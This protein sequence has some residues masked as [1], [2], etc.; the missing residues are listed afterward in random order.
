MYWWRCSSSCILL[1][2][3]LPFAVVSPSPDRCGTLENTKNP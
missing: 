3:G 1:V 2:C